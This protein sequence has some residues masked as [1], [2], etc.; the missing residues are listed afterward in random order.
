MGVAN[1]S[2]AKFSRNSCKLKQSIKAAY[3]VADKSAAE[4]SRNSRKLKQSINGGSR[5]KCC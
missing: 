2:A 3:G 1:K 5:Q 4:I